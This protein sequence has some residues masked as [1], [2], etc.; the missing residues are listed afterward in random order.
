MRYEQVLS[1]QKEGSVFLTRDVVNVDRQDDMAALYTFSSSFLSEV[2]TKCDT[3]PS[4]RSLVV[5]LFVLGD[6]CDSY[7]NRTVGHKERVLM[8][9]RG[10]FFLNGWRT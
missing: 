9:M 5:Y 8:A 4:Y 2:V 3:D 10:W 6:L 7:L 1:I